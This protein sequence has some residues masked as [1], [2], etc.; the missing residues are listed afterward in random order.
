[1]ENRFQK[2]IDY[3]QGY[4]SGSKASECAQ[5]MAS[6]ERGKNARTENPNG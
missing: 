2:T 3:L 4:I 1:M 5:E 6:W